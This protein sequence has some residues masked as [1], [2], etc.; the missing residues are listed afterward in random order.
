MSTKITKIDKRQVLR[1]FD[2][3]RQTDDH[4]NDLL[5]YASDNLLGHFSL[6]AVITR[7]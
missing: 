3:H 4:R 6:Q 1:S 5:T 7:N 2:G